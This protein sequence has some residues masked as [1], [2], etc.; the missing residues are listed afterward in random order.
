[1]LEL[2]TQL[3]TARRF[4]WSRH[5]QLYPWTQELSSRLDGEMATEPKE[6]AARLYRLFQVGLAKCL[7]ALIKFASADRV[8]LFCVHC[9]TLVSAGAL[10]FFVVVQF[11]HLPCDRL[12]CPEL[13]V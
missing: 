6:G 1:M 10:C 9:L 5:P 8:A 13:A 2:D 3:L 11:F 7:A 4:S 12:A